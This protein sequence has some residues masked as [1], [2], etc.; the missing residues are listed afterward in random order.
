MSIEPVEDQERLR[1]LLKAETVIVYK[2]STRCSISRRTMAQM[3]E[4]AEQRPDV[5]VAMVDVVAQRELSD[6]IARELKVRHKSPQAIVVKDGE[7]VWE[8]SHFSIKAKVLA[9]RLG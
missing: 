7:A 9:D 6:L 2:H 4:F 5:P 8:T 3:Q 1:E